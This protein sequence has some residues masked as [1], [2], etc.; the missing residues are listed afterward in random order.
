M[1]FMTLV[2]E[3]KCVF[4]AMWVVL[5][6][7]SMQALE[8]EIRTLLKQF[9]R[10]L[11]DESR[12]CDHDM[13]SIFRGR[14]HFIS[15]KIAHGVHIEGQTRGLAQGGSDDGEQDL[16]D[17]DNEEEMNANDD[18][19]DEAP[20]VG[21]IDVSEFRG[22]ISSSPAFQ[23]FLDEIYNLAFP[24][25]KK[26]L[27]RLFARWK[28]KGKHPDSTTQVETIVGE[29]A[30]SQPN[31]ITITQQPPGWVNQLKG[32][33]EEF[34]G[35]PWEWWPLAPKLKPLQKGQ[36]QIMWN[37]KCSRAR[38]EVVPREFAMRLKKLVDKASITSKPPRRDS[39][40]A[41]PEP[42]HHSPEAGPS[43]IPRMPTSHSPRHSSTQMAPDSSIR[44]RR[45]FHVME[46][47]PLRAIFFL[48]YNGTIF[49][50]GRGLKRSKIHSRSLCD[51]LFYSQMREEY[52]KHRGWWRKWLG[53]Y[54]FEGCDFYLVSTLFGLSIAACLHQP[55]ASYP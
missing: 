44:P 36:V 8:L 25:F 3:D 45:A 46:A 6:N 4:E 47:E 16:D 24:S 53:L 43:T 13:S 33:I 35:E 9:V 27:E 15:R 48:V 38:T 21:D 18:Q 31:V 2:F 11:R 41:V 22:L 54:T 34:T 14:S 20:E 5:S 1:T 55:L 42:A 49:P 23:L 26:T 19:D 37:C 10:A 7:Y 50:W 28:R 52:W 29:L 30:Y 51:N 32:F 40:P 39:Q 12:L 17:G